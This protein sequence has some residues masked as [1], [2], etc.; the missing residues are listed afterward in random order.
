[1]ER[2]QPSHQLVLAAFHGTTQASADSIDA[3]CCQCS[4]ALHNKDVPRVPNIKKGYNP[5]TWMLDVS[6]SAAEA[7]LDVDFAKNYANYDLYENRQQDLLNLLGATC[8]VVL[9]LGA[10]NA[11][12][13]QSV[14]AIE[15]TVFYRERAAGMYS[16]LQY[17]FAQT[18]I[19]TIYV[20]I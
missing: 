16:E 9:L 8:A 10:T 11:S 7:Q 4:V 13:V 1:M 6:Y 12:A 19:E 14:V 3:I 15:R 5:T 18:A 17:A 20:A 2:T